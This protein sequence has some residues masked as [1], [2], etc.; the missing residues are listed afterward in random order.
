LSQSG[1]IQGREDADI[2]TASDGYAGRFAGQ[3]GRFFLETQ[4]RITLDLI[5]DW[6]GGRVLEVGGGHAQLT[7]ALVAGGYRVVVQGSD[8]VCRARLERSLEPAGYGFVTSDLLSLPFEDRSF[9]VVTAFRL[10]P[11]VGRWPELIAE[12]CRVAARAVVV[13]YPDL[14]SFNL[15]SSG[16]FKA[17]KAVEGNTRPYQ[18]FWGRRIIG[19]FARH[20]FGQASLR[21]QFLWPMVVHRALNLAPLSRLVEALGR[22]SGLTRLLGSPVILRVVRSG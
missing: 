8:P 17:K 4:A 9:E 10:L 12:M 15:F 18:C 7:P 21:P 2:E 6:A 20:G 22:G 16:L 3:V 19:Q 11:H 1:R 5:Q 13:D 14:A